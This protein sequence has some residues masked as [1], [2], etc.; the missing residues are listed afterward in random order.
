VLDSL[1]VTGALHQNA[2]HG[3]RGGG[4]KMAAAIPLAIFASAGHAQVG[5]VDERSGLEGLML[6]ALARQTG[7]RQLP[8]F[9]IH[10]RQQV[11]AVSRTVP[12]G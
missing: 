7:P 6:V 1:I 3:E 12:V 4:E 10:F 5:F 2:A 9:V 8:E 11:A